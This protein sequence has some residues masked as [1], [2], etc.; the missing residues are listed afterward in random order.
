MSITIN[1]LFEVLSYG[2]LQNLA[3]GVEGNGAIEEQAQPKVITAANEALLKL[4]Q[5]F[6][7]I[8][9]QVLVETRAHITNYHLIPEY[10]ESA[11][12]P[13]KVRYPYIKDLPGEKFLDDVLRILFVYDSMGNKLP[14]NNQEHPLSLFTPKAKV[15]QVPRPLEGVMLSVSYQARHPQLTRDDLDAEIQIPDVLLAALTGYIGYAMFSG[16]GTAESTAK[17]AEYIGKYETTCTE[18]EEFDSLST[19]ISQTNSRFNKN[20]WI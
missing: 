19:T 7:M 1:S 18:V 17:A 12:D 11:Y 3:S 13:S 5:R 6:P 4:C 8:E 15:L 14:L 10:S 16:I 20:G 2:E 9:K